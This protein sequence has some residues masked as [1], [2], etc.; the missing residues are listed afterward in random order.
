MDAVP[1]VVCW[2]HAQSHP[3]FVTPWTVARQA[4][5]SMGFF[6]QEYGIG[7]PF[8]TPGLQG[9]FP[10]Q[11]LNPRLLCILHWQADSLLAVQVA[12]LLSRVHPYPSK[13]L[14]LFFPFWVVFLLGAP[15]DSKWQCL[16][17]RNWTWNKLRKT[18]FLNCKALYMFSVLLLLLLT[19]I[20]TIIAESCGLS[21]GWSWQLGHGK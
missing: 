2:V 6:R 21:E 15:R 14:S 3:L 19:K 1:F 7:L 13:Y 20:V 10:T 18:F 5:P 4:P 17:R 16:F 8:R 12:S 11:G 9:I